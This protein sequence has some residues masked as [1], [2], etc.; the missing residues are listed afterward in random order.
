MTARTEGT[1][2]YRDIM[3]GLNL[4]VWLA[5]ELTFIFLSALFFASV[6][7]YCEKYFPKID[8]Y[9]YKS[10]AQFNNECYDI[11]DMFLPQRNFKAICFAIA[12]DS[13]SK[14][15]FR[16]PTNEIWQ[17]LYNDN[18]K[19]MFYE[20]NLKTENTGRFGTVKEMSKTVNYLKKEVEVMT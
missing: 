4:S 8:T 15:E 3:K 7:S 1:W 6:Q 14:R 12:K 2:V 16:G 9:L 11:V 18:Q 10:K 19:R 5:Q 13:E 17:L 20:N